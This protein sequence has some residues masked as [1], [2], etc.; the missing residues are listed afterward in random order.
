MC[1]HFY[2]I[3]DLCNRFDLCNDFLIFSLLSSFHSHFTT[4]WILRFQVFWLIL[5]PQFLIYWLLCFLGIWLLSFPHFQ[6]FRL[7]SFKGFLLFCLRHLDSSLWGIS[8][9]MFK[10][11]FILFWQL[12][13]Y[14]LQIYHFQFKDCDAFPLLEYFLTTFPLSGILE[15]LLHVLFFLVTPRPLNWGMSDT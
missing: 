7:L 11:F 12:P 13:V 14:R 5:T 4:F 15:Q 3:L 10:W 2:R 1:N 6:G 9:L 8:T